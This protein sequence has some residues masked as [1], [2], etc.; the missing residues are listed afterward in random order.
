MTPPRPGATAVGGLAVLLLTA[1]GPA[2]RSA[3]APVA[4]V[5]AERTRWA[6][7]QRDSDAVQ[8]AY[9][10]TYGFPHAVEVD[11]VR[12]AID[13]EYSYTVTGFRAQP[14]PAGGEP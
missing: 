6:E 7:L 11:K 3:G 1:C 9:D 10:P 5:S 13:D 2:D 14:E 8:V 4:A 12:D